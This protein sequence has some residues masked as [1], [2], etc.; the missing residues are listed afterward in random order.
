[1]RQGGMGFSVSGAQQRTGGGGSL[2]SSSEDELGRVY[3]GQVVIRLFSYV[4]LYRGWALFSLAAVLVYT[5]ATVCIP[6]IVKW[7]IDSNI[8][9][10]IGT[11]KT[12]NLGLVIVVFAITSVV[13]YVSN[14]LQFVGISKVGQGILYSM[15]TQLFN[16][17]QS[18]SPSFFARTEVGRIMSRV[19]NDIL[20]LQETFSL[21][22][23]TLADV[24][25]LVGI[26]SMMM[27][28]SWKLSL[29]T[30]AVLPILVLLMAFWQKFAKRSFVRIRTAIAMVNGALQEN[31]AGVR[32]VQSFNRQ[33]LNLNRFDGLNRE[34]LN[35]NIQASMYSGGVQPLVEGLTG[36]SMGFVILV[37]GWWVYNGTLEV[38]VL[39]AF[40][41]FIQRFFDP[42]RNLTM[43]YTQLQRS[44]AS[45]VRIF[46]LLDVKPEIE[47]KPDAE[48][49]PLIEGDVKFKGVNFHYIEGIPVLENVDFS[50]GKG[51]TIALV[52]PTGA[53]KST[54][55]NLMSR[56]YDVIDGTVE[57]DGI[58]IK[59]VKR[60]SLVTQMSMVLQQ[61][62]LISDTVWEN[63]RYCHQEV[64][65]ESVIESAKLVG[66]HDF[67]I[68]LEHGYDTVLDERGSNLSIGQ[69]QLISFA[70]AIAANPRILVLDEATS[71]VD[72][73]S[74]IMIQQALQKVLKDRTAFVIA[75][76]LS[77]I[78]NV[79]KIFVIN[80]GS[81]IESGTH[82]EL[83]NA[84]GFYFQLNKINASLQAGSD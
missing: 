18:L 49:M 45:G 11:G 24:L 40:I 14:Y 21:L 41:L 68:A 13:H 46:Q 19:Q 36:I 59:D 78:R 38:G 72:T 63:I 32:V 29:L 9:P 12:S 67:I 55:I 65:D 75:H 26:I 8:Q 61:P 58:N 4:G 47:D 6:V 62:Y 84:G 79:D 44:M 1:M 60:E 20:Q 25:S 30:F 73:Y 48:D 2:V 71:N 31:L 64:S 35:A 81:I 39:V 76:R 66:I 50:V 83:I 53:G 70:R 10:F 27:I 80:H 33:S 22:V 56:F 82:E 42:I 16:H 77:T 15:R 69:R 52:G 43:Q 57:I 54:I 74:D 23:L 34:H 37:G 17:L 3:D 51:Q 5:A 28:M 7:G